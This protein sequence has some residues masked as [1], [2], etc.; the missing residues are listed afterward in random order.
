MSTLN[1]VKSF[2]ICEHEYKTKTEWS[3][4]ERKDEFHE[5]IKKRWSECRICNK[6]NPLA[7][8]EIETYGTK[9]FHGQLTEILDVEQ[10]DLAFSLLNEMYKGKNNKR[11]PPFK[12][13]LLTKYPY[14]VLASTVECLHDYGILKI[15]KRKVK[16]D[17][18]IKQI[19]YNHTY[20]KDIFTFLG[21]QDEQLPE[22][23]TNPF[24]QLV[25]PTTQT[26]MVISNFLL[27]QKVMFERTQEGTILNPLSEEIVVASKSSAK[28]YF[29]LIRMV[30]GIFENVEKNR[31]EYWKTFSQ[32]IFGDTKVIKKID[33]KR[34]EQLFGNRLEDYGILS[35]R[36]EVIVSGDFTWSY[37]G[38]SNTSR[39]FKDY[40]S[41]P[42]NMINE[43]SITSWSS[44]SLLIIENPALFFSV[45]KS[46]LLDTKEWSVMLGS[47]FI[48][49]Q[50]IEI[51]IQACKGQLKKVHIWPDLDPYGYQIANDIY[52]KIKAQKLSV[53]LFGYTSEWFKRMDLYK[54]LELYDVQVI[55][56]LLTEEMLHKEVRSLFIEMKN[57]NKKAEQ[58]ILFSHLDKVNIIEYLEKSIRL[59]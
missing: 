37:N 52:S 40:I 28:G 35:E 10:R 7:S 12:N 53:Y 11:W 56:Q 6:V 3:S 22:W 58:E 19:R 39:A 2:S 24:P 15:L 45:V 51:I 55:D 59:E 47:G 13:K 46:H 54:E 44:S 42:R 26:S 48:S 38:Y 1:S 23:L 29:K 30:Y 18:E 41:F 32:R 21:I 57:E 20:E 49:S 43:M 8:T 33:K 36:T 14:D 50:E 5:R 9:P 34:L 27:E 31:K 16:F 4:F 25:N 17:G